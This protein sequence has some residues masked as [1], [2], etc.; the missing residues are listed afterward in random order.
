[1][2]LLSTGDTASVA[3]ASAIPPAAPI[4]TAPISTQ[5]SQGLSQGVRA[6]LPVQDILAEELKLAP[7][8]V[9]NALELF[10]EGATVPFIARYRKERT[11]EMN[12]IVLRA[13]F[14][15]YEYLL[16]LEDRKQTVLDSIQQQGKLTDELRAKI[17]NCLQKN[18]LEDL[19]L[20]FKP[21]R[22]TRA[23]IAR[24]KGL[25]PLAEAILAMNAPDAPQTP[26]L[27]LAE[28]FVSAKKEVASAEDALRGASDI[29]A[30]II[31][32]K[33]ELRAALRSHI[34]NN[35]VIASSI[36]SEKYPEGTTKYE[37]Y[38]SY[39]APL[40]SVAAHNM[41]ALRRGEAEE[42]L[43][44]TIQ[45]DEEYA[46]AYLESK[47]IHTAHHETADFLKKTVRDAFARL[48]KFT[49]IGE[50]RL[51]KKKE[52]DAAS[53]AAFGEN[54]R[55]VL[56]ASPAGMKPTLGID[57]GFRTGCK[58][59]AV[60]KTGKFLEYRAIFPH[61]SAR[62]REEAKKTL[63]AM[64]E[65]NGVELIAIGNGTAGRE[66]DE[67]VAE[68]LRDWSAQSER[69]IIK[70][71][72]NESGASVY[73]ASQVALEEFPE[74]DVSVRGAISIARRLQDPLAELVKIDPKSI[75]VGQYQH[76]VDQKLLKK[77]LEETVETCVNFVGVDV[78][79][80]SKELLRFVAGITE[81]VAKNIVEYR[82]ANGAFASRKDLLSVAKFGAKTF[83]QAAG[84]LRVRGADGKAPL[85]PLD[86]SAVHPERYD[87]VEKMASDIGLDVASMIGSSEAVR[88]INL[89]KYV[90]DEIGEPTL[91]DILKELEK[92]GRDPRAEFRY[93]EFQ[94]GINTIA[95]L[96]EGMIVEGVVT[97]V[98]NFG[99]F[100][101]VGVHQDGLVHISQL[102]NRFVANPLEVVK[103]GQIV[104]ARVLEV[105]TA[106]KRIQLSLKQAAG[107]DSN[108]SAASAASAPAR[109]Q[110]RSARTND[111]PSSESASSS[112]EKLKEKFAKSV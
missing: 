41:L 101:D 65:R 77:K 53:I 8:H 104:K 39:S 3:S 112:L 22:R 7:Q 49:L 33:A 48:M 28:G 59:A 19:Y 32:E 98:T 88:K 45:F 105:N 17:E 96:R 68:T 71:M 110:H 91:R 54:L 26:L 42:I 12:E 109:G 40:K 100:V 15:R 83:E 44:L 95:D 97:N 74:L 93:A 76:D 61:N 55:N 106:L 67:F 62:E 18:E 58:V 79:T 21:K 86:N 89:S 2:N 72:V 92:P 1:M 73:S 14:D 16:E 35:A 99:A 78:N 31:A 27:L 69:K 56:L 25:E 52:A 6:R 111:A 30:E 75:G 13:L 64:I 20:P 34:L 84:F 82:N 50:V 11:G 85:N 9:H 23:A 90:G 66:T 87:I 46:L 108:A 60:D 102:A 5:R 36:D 63:L 37:M 47:E 94:S 43:T 57:P 29:I 4:S 80:A 24:E 10:E 81:T 107:G 51:E 38:R 70:V 103:V